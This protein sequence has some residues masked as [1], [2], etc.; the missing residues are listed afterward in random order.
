MAKLGGWLSTGDPLV[1]EAVARAGF[2]FVG[3][4]LQHGGYGLVEAARTLQIIDLVGVPSLVRLSSEELGTV[5]RYLDFGATA[6][7]VATVDG[8]DIAERAVRL[9][10]H[11]PDGDRSDGGSRRFSLAPAGGPGTGVQVWTMIETRAGLEAVEDIARVPGLYG[12]AVGPADLARA[13]G[14]PWERRLDD[15][16]WCAGVDRVLAVAKAAGLATCIFAGSGADARAWG[17]HGFDH[18]VLSNDLD[19]LRSAMRRELQAGRG[20]GA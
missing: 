6:V 14:V 13:L 9:T 16:G 18:V 20:D 7:M 12:L 19:L 11:Q 1:A 8:P 2:D 4:D 17:A 5:P 3:L 15:A 10:R